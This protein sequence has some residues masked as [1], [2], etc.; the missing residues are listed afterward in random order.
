METNF[1]VGSLKIVSIPLLDYFQK[2]NKNIK[3]NIELINEKKVAVN[4]ESL[5]IIKKVNGTLKMIGLVGITKVLMN[6]SEAL[7]KVKENKFDSQ[8]SLAILENSHKSIENIVYYVQNLLNGELDQP[9][10]LYNDYANLSTLINKS[11]NV[12][13]LFLPKLDFRNNVET[14]LQEDLR[15][16]ILLNAKTKNDLILS[17]NKINTDIQ[18]LLLSLFESLNKKDYVL[19]KSVYQNIIKSFYN[20][21]EQQQKLHISKNIY[22]YNGIQKLFLC[23]ISPL[24]ND[25]CETLIENNLNS[26]KLNLSKFEKVNRHIIDSINPMDIGSRTG[27]I[28]VDDEIVK[29]L[30]YFVINEVNKTENISLKNMPVFVELDKIF[31]MDFYLNQLK[32]INVQ[33]TLSQKNPELVAQIDKLFVDI[34]ENL[35]LIFGKNVKL[36]NNPNLNRLVSSSSKFTELLSSTNNQELKLLTQL[37]NNTINSIK[38]NEIAITEALQKEL[39]LSLVFIEYGINNFIKSNNGSNEDFSQQSSKQIKRLRLAVDNKLDELAK[40]ELPQ[41]DSGS[42]KTDERKSFLVIFDK[43]HKDLKKSEEILNDIFRDSSNIDELDYV[44]KTLTSAKGIFAIINKDKLSALLGDV[45]NVWKDVKENGLNSVNKDNLSSSVSVLSGILLFVESSKNGNDSEAEEMY[46]LILQKA[47]LVD[48][49]ISLTPKP[50]VVEEN[51]EIPSIDEHIDNLSLSNME[52]LNSNNLSLSTDSISIEEHDLTK[53]VEKSISDYKVPTSL[54]QPK[55]MH[56]SFVDKAEDQELLEVFMEETTDVFANIEKTVEALKKDLN[57]KEEIVNIRRYFHTLKGS[58]RMVGLINMGEAAWIVEQTLNKVISDDL[59]FNI[60]MLN[61]VEKTK[62][63]FISWASRLKNEGEVNVDLVN[64]KHIWAVHNNNINTTF[65]IPSSDVTIVDPVSL[66]TAIEKEEILLTPMEL[67]LEEPKKVESFDS[68]LNEVDVG[69]DNINLDL[70]VDVMPLDIENELNSLN[71][72]VNDSVDLSTEHNEEIEEEFKFDDVLEEN[73]ETNEESENIVIGGQEVSSSLYALFRE[74][75]DLHLVSLNDEVNSHNINNKFE[76]NKDFMRHAH[77]LSSIGRSVNLSDFSDLVSKIEDLSDLAIEKNK[78]LNETNFNKLKIVVH[79][80][81]D[82]SNI[83]DGSLG[84]NVL[85]KKMKL[86]LDDVVEYLKQEDKEDVQ[87]SKNLMQVPAIDIE[88]IVLEITNN[89]KYLVNENISKLNYSIENLNAKVSEIS[90]SN[91]SK[92]LDFNMDN[93]SSSVSKVVHDVLNKQ[94]EK[95]LERESENNEKTASLMNAIEVLEGSIKSLSENQE[96]IEKQHK[97]NFETLQKYLRAINSEIKK[98]FNVQ[99]SQ[100]VQWLQN[101]QG[102]PEVGISPNPLLEYNSNNFSSLDDISDEESL[103]F[104]DIDT[105]GSLISDQDIVSDEQV[106]LS[107]KSTQIVLG[108][109]DIQSVDEVVPSEQVE[110]SEK[111]NEIVLNDLDIQSVEENNLEQPIIIESKSPEIS[112]LAISDN[113][114]TEQVIS[115]TN[116]LL[117]H[118]EF[119]NAI[120]EEKVSD[121][122]DELDSDILE[123]SSEENKELLDKIDLILSNDDKTFN[124]DKS[125]ELKRLLHTLKGNFRMAGANKIGSIAHRLES[126]LDYCESRQISINLIKD[127]LEEEIKKIKFLQDGIFAFMKAGRLPVLDSEKL[128]WLNKLNDDFQNDV[129]KNAT[130]GADN[131]NIA[132]SEQNI[133]DIQLFNKPIIK[134]EEKQFVRVSSNIIDDLIN[135]VGELRLT[136]TTLEGVLSGNRRNLQE[137]SNSSNKLVKMLKEIEVQAE[138]QIQSTKEHMVDEKNFDPLEF[139]RFTR[140]QELTRLMTEAVADV[141]DTILTLDE[142]LTTQTSTIS[143]QS[144]LTNTVLDS[145]MKVR[146]LQFDTLSPR[147]Y[148]ITRNTSKELGKKVSLYLQGYKTEIDRLVLDKISAPLEHLLRNSIAHGIESPEE[149]ISKGKSSSGDI[150]IKIMSESNYITINIKDDGAGINLDKVREIGIKKGLISA[151]KRYSE[152]EIIDLIFL[153]G[154]STSDSISQVSGR[155]V[156]MDVVKKDISD[157]GGSIEVKTKK[158]IGTEFTITLPVSL[159]T[160]QAMLTK[161]SNKLIAIPALLIDQVYSLKKDTIQEAYMSGKVK[162]KDKEYPF[163]YLGHLLGLMP[164][165]QLPEFKIYNSLIS[166]NYLGETIFI[167]IDSIETTSDILMK[168]MGRFFSK[169]EGVLGATLLGDGRQGLV[170]NPVM[171]KHHFDKNIK[172]NTVGDIG[173]DSSDGVRTGVLTVMVVDD[174]ITVRRATLKVLERYGFNVILAKDG[175]DGLEQLQIAIPDII[176][177]DI[178]MPKM[179]GFEFAKNI[180]NNPKYENIPIIMITS[181]TAD[182]H[183]N[184]ALSL[185]VDG[186]LGKPYNENELIENIKKLTGDLN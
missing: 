119:L 172:I 57:N 52:D 29:E 146:L 91:T 121:V 8:K 34:K 43:L 56:L 133:V 141:N 125:T 45:I 136:R 139:D 58:G 68:I 177:S 186:F 157:L 67:S 9:N 78:P 73:N 149:R 179:D 143:Q 80:L 18:T 165:S 154:F 42:Q 90:N 3:E 55:E 40:L 7:S 180:K 28:K 101:E 20:S 63:I 159:A 148:S 169:I 150:F 82:F 4:F 75:A 130:T 21:I 88:K 51:I 37:F 84:E 117:E 103:D 64:I 59:A 6:I 167:H 48:N 60:R 111:S 129:E 85:F 115:K 97:E 14:A 110:L 163:Y 22:L 112:H 104:S 123:I 41:L 2:I 147:L 33:L 66:D 1:N 15:V 27:T 12:K 183:K 74:E 171:L 151:D 38:N 47:K 118:K 70:P 124:I 25:N 158:D 127:L 114:T 69:N 17:L 155:G 174:S 93:L 142:Y 10:K 113:V 46:K 175:E 99:N 71:T 138:S 16:G 184:H 89:V 152:N 11:H 36:E 185:G 79:H 168:S 13:D 182:K 24:F 137:L 166:I 19:N 144:I 106:E 62:N 108:D 131:A 120:F 100:V 81:G 23:L 83:T 128:T 87:S 134:K 156:G 44:F 181:R 176:L 96:K 173:I 77:T 109:L 161:V 153:S 92:Q 50:V 95:L 162:I 107:E 31:N 26:I 54:D 86:D 65:D 98:K 72:S 5:E 164:I 135:E 94:N 116:S 126:L 170:I 61:D 39:S 32:D 53:E 160:N 140:L 145:L 122:V 76:I 102:S 30:L 49:D 35:S 132:K 178:E 105:I